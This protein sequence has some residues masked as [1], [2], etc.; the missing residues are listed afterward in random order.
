MAEDKAGKHVNQEIGWD[1]PG[2]ND[3]VTE[4]FLRTAPVQLEPYFHMPAEDD[5]Q[6]QKAE[7][8]KAAE[9]LRMCNDEDDM[10][11]F[12]RVYRWLRAA[13]CV[14]PKT[15]YHEPYS[16]HRLDLPP[17][18]SADVSLFYVEVPRQRDWPHKFTKP[19]MRVHIPDMPPLTD[20]QSFLANAFENQVEVIRAE[21]R[22]SIDAKLYEEEGP[23]LSLKKTLGSNHV[24]DDWLKSMVQS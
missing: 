4:L 7:A 18:V 23:T 5:I 17:G 9:Y 8:R 14:A 21:I 11:H 20:L 6:H 19:P 12:L 24:V 2:R 15:R 10:V 13:L 22:Y 1:I 3:L 16:G